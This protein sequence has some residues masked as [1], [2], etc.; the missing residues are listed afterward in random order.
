M[1][2]WTF[3]DSAAMPDGTAISLHEHDGDYYVQINGLDLMSTRRH[4]S[5]EKIAELACAR[6]KTLPGARV[7]IG[8]LGF[9]YTLKAALACLAPDATV[10]MVEVVAAVIAWNQNPAYKL[11]AQALADPRVILMQEDVAEVIRNSPGRFDSIILD[12]DN[13]TVALST[14]GNS[15]L[16]DPAGLQLAR[17]ALRP[18]GS[19]AFW[20][21]SSDP[22]FEKRLA[23]AGFSVSVERCRPHANSGGWHTILMGTLRREA[24]A[25]P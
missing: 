14:E 13:G 20:S 22:A 12:V 5:E 2:K 10:V 9:G 3:I 24:S 7:L 23:R 21:A 19:V 15:R 11:A 16:Y 4:A 1:K 25:R 8:G 18:G 6:A 17:A